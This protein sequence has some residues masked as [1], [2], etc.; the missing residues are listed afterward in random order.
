MP[1]QSLAQGLLRE[2]WTEPEGKTLEGSL[3][4]PTSNES[5]AEETQKTGLL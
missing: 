2:L 1:L 3:M 4:A 5:V